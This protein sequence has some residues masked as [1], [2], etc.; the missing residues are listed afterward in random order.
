MGDR[1][2]LASQG[3]KNAILEKTQHPGTPCFLAAMAVQC[4]RLR[5]DCDRLRS[6]AFEISQGQNPGWCFRRCVRFQSR[7]WHK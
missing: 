4:D 6:E 5:S 1:R 7:R 3:P 2:L